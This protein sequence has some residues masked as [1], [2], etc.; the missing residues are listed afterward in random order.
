MYNNQQ[1]QNSMNQNPATQ[2]Q[3]NSSN[4]NN[5]NVP[6]ARA[7]LDNMK[8]EIASELGINL[9]PGYNGDLP[10]RQAGYIGGYMVNLLQ[11][12]ERFGAYFQ[13]PPIRFARNSLRNQFDQMVEY[14]VRVGLD[15]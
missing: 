10:S 8:F 3:Q 5:I 13:L 12:A 14:H 4:S 2:N 9:K 7:A 1:N 11:P 15:L 6:E